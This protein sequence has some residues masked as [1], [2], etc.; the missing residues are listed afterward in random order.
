MPYGAWLRIKKPGNPYSADRIAVIAADAA[1]NG[2]NIGK[3]SGFGTS[4]ETGISDHETEKSSDRCY[5]VR[6][7]HLL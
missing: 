5:P 2:E 4:S 6:N 3:R 7:L 1:T